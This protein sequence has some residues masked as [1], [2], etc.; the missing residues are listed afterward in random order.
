M[1]HVGTEI[2]AEVA[3]QL[4]E[5][6][7]HSVDTDWYVDQLY[8]FTDSLDCSVISARYSRYT[9]DLNRDADGAILYPGQS[10]TELCPTYSFDSNSLYLD[11]V[12]PSD[13]EI[14]R[15]KAAYWQPYHDTIRAEL[16]RI[17]SKFGY[18]LLWDAHSIQSE[19]PR[20][21]EGKLPDLNLGTGNGSSCSETTAKALLEIGEDSP[22][23]TVLNG[24]FKGGYIT[25]HY[26]KPENDIHA[27]QMEISQI[28]YMDEAPVLRFHE[29]KAE[30][31]RPTL[32]AMLHHFIDRYRSY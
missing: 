12:F 4:T 8:D 13:Q 11:D 2:P 28:N 9:I 23:K 31:L 26:G 3:E 14:L 24:R 5:D 19:V 32:N 16:E 25:R 10:E 20:F 15:R 29:D 6:A 1:P 27:V 18:A 22:Y 7:L 21:F 30:Q 17:K